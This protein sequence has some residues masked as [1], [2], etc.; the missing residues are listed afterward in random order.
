M[1]VMGRNLKSTSGWAN[2]GNGIDSFGFYAIGNDLR[3]SGGYWGGSTG[4]S[5]YFWT[6]SNGD[7]ESAWYRLLEYG[8]KEIERSATMK[9]FGR[10]VRCVKN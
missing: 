8:Y 6:S 3:Y 4:F 5:A 9:G 10:N 2:D 7:G 1:T